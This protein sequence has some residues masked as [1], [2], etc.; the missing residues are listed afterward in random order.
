MTRR[1]FARNGKFVLAPTGALS[2]LRFLYRCRVKQL[3]ASLII[4]RH[5]KQDI[6]SQIHHRERACPPRPPSTRQTGKINLS[7]C[8]AAPIAAVHFSTL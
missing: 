1:K 6:R 4:I 5:H 2:Y 8:T 3:A 7:K